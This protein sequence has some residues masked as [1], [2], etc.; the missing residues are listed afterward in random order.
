M[1]KENEDGTE[2]SEEPTSKRKG[3]AKRKGQVAQSQDFG[4]GIMLAAGFIAL[5]ILGDDLWHAIQLHFVQSIKLASTFEYTEQYMLI[6]MQNQ[7]RWMAR[8]LLPLMLTFLIVG[9]TTAILQKGFGWYWE[10][11][12]PDFGKVFSPKKLASGLKKIFFS[13]QTLFNLGKNLLKMIA[14][15]IVIYWVLSDRFEELLFLIDHDFMQICLIILSIAA[16]I[17]WK[18]IL[19]L[20]LIGI[21]DFI[22]QKR[23]LHSELKMTKQ[24]VKDENKQ[25]MGD[26]K[27]LAKRKQMLMQMYQSN[28]MK[29][30]PEATV[31]ITNP[32]FI[33]IALRYRQ[34]EDNVPLVLGKGKRKV[35]EKI[36]N[37]AEEHNIPVVQN[38]PLARAM[39]DQIDV[40]D[41]IPAEFYNS[42]AEIL[43]FVISQ[44]GKAA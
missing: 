32:T 20:I 12:K 22:Y 2:K 39:Y 18:V 26:P 33:A 23:K 7:L 14:I 21:I 25:V 40:G 6:L 5:W 15:S 41:T 35:A 3:E 10:K 13:K 8:N 19:L 43:A 1:A 34:G 38:K 4:N 44:K 29:Q 11:L 27:V 36:R 37:I 30:V 9:M 31:V 17:A 42:V 24:E 28:M 16:E